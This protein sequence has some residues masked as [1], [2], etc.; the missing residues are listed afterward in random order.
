[1]QNQCYANLEV[2]D[3]L[4]ATASAAMGCD[5]SVFNRFSTPAEWDKAQ[6][7]A[8]NLRDNYAALYDLVEASAPSDPNE[9]ENLQDLYS[10]FS[11]IDGALNRVDGALYR[12]LHEPTN[13]S[14]FE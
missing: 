1:M 10:A 9:S 11:D 14:Y 4:M 2:F 7:F 3:G 5:L 6:S 12:Y 8:R 13:R